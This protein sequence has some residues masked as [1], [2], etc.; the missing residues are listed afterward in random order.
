MDYTNPYQYVP[1][2]QSLSLPQQTQ[3]IY[4]P[5]Q[6]TP[7][8]QSPSLPQQAQSPLDLPNLSQ[9]LGNIGTPAAAPAAAPVPK[10]TGLGSSSKGIPGLGSLLGGG[11]SSLV[12]LLGGNTAG[13]VTGGLASLGKLLG[14]LT[15]T[16]VGGAIGS[17]AG[18]GLGSLL[19]T[20]TIS[21]L[22]L[23]GILPAFGGKEMGGQMLASALTPA[24][25]SMLGGAGAGALSTAA[26]PTLS[27]I[28][29]G[30][31]SFS[32][33]LGP[34]GLI[35][36]P[37]LGTITG[38]GE[39]HEALRQGRLLEYTAKDL[40]LNE[41]YNVLAKEL[42]PNNPDLLSYTS[43]GSYASQ[44]G[45]NLPIFDYETSTTGRDDFIIQTGAH[46]G[47][48][49]RTLASKLLKESRDRGEQTLPPE[50]EAL[51]QRGVEQGSYEGGLFGWALPPSS[52]IMGGG[53][54]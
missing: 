28:L 11:L 45:V 37:I 25:A 33:M 51:Q 20:G 7:N 35:A 4:D 47:E 30:L 14:G 42:G 3:T 8:L 12:K 52:M 22:S 13:A 18:G 44:M 10:S 50:L 1:Y 54:A 24:F 32:D 21:P 43:K 27:S 15:G 6:Y 5:F 36:M 2:L 9:L 48:N 39:S 40:W 19:S 23:A 53:G 16:P 26:A 41:L 29:G 34:L 31:T 17:I 46:A 49:I 38:M